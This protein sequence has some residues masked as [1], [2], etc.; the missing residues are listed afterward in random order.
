MKN[1]HNE[2]DKNKAQ[3]LQTAT[4]PLL[5]SENLNL[6]RQQARHHY[7]PYLQDSGKVDHKLEKRRNR[8]LKFFQKGEK[9]QLIENQRK[10]QRDALIK[11][12]KELER[13][14]KEEKLQEKQI[15]QGYLPDKSKNEQY[16]ISSVSSIPDIEWWDVPFLDTVKNTILAKYHN[17]YSKLDPEDDS[18]SED[19]ESI[20]P[21][22]R[23]I[24]HP[25]PPN[26][27]DDSLIAK[28]YLTRKE[29]KKLRRNRRKKDREALEQR[30]KEG[31]EP[32]PEPRIK[33]SN[34]MSVFENNQNITDPTAWEQTVKNQVQARHDK[35]LENNEI[36]H[37]EAK[38]KRK[39]LNE[40]L[41]DKPNSDLIC[42][43]F[44]F[45]NL[46]NPQIRYKINTNCKQL[47]LKGTCLRVKDDGHGI[48]VIYG[49]EK[50]CKRF[51]K[52]VLQRIKW[53]LPFTDK[54]TQQ[55]I[56][57]SGNTCKIIWE[58]PIEECNFRGFFM[59]S[60]ENK[61]ELR[62]ILKNS[63][64]EFLLNSPNLQL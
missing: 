32:K 25:I 37:L 24:H 50:S 4:N 48:I 1:Q 15:K 36:R 47:Y 43:L 13:R 29:S 12:E 52:L 11:N 14:A 63:N 60:C 20:H 28:V 51:Q 18:D 10:E 49:S 17:N 54:S 2:G 57:M 45:K 41:L 27:N 39:E 26:S 6:V 64:A 56:S 31:L 61:N 53:D 3:G 9:V 40:K 35:H 22:I 33:L 62:E 16:I 23:F 42:K 59:K 58:G 30:I 55:E 8:G 44:W 7:N 19:E 5:L 34:M 46:E 21:S 38:A